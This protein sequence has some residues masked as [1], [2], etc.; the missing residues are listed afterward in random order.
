M[1][2]RLFEDLVVSAPSARLR[3][4][5]AL[6]PA[7]AAVHA[8]VVALALLLPVVRPGESPEPVAQVMRWP[9]TVRAVTPPPRGDPAPRPAPTPRGL[10]PP[11]PPAVVATPPPAPGPIVS[12]DATTPPTTGDVPSP[13][14]TGCD[15]VARPD[16][17]GDGPGEDG[18]TGIPGAAA[19]T[20]APIRPGGDIQP[21]RRVVYVPPVYPEIAKQARVGGTVV[22]DCTIDRDGRVVDVSV[23]SGHPLL[24]EAALSAVRR[25][26][27]TP[28]RLNGVPIPVLMTVTVRFTPR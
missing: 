22:L 19:G 2:R 15:P 9:T 4:R 23:I 10:P 24:D 1:H 28:T 14:L 8:A 26:T 18:A 21:P 5:A 11:V 6:M 13:C 16:G 20:D 25:W 3:R 12:I 27:Y 17:S 7:S